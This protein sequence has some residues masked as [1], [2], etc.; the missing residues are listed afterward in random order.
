MVHF[1]PTTSNA[2]AIDVANLFVTYVWKLHG[3]PKKT[4]SDR[5]PNFNSKFLRQLYKRLDI[6]PSFSTAYRSQTD[7]QSERANQVVEGFLRHYVSHRQ[8]NWVALLPMAEFSY[9]NGVQT[10]T[11]KTPFFACYGFHPQ[12]TIGDTDTK[13]VPAA[14]ERADWLKDSFDE[15]RAALETSNQKIKEF[16]DRKHR[17][18]VKI[19]IGDKV[20]IDSRDIQTDRPSK[21]LAAKRLGPFQVLEKIGT[22]AFKLKLPHTMK[23]H[24][25]F[26]VSKVTLKQ[27]DPYEREPVPLPPIITPEGEEEFEVETVLNSK[28]VRGVVKYLIKWKGYGPADNTWEPYEHLVNAKDALAIWD[29][30][31]LRV[32]TTV[33]AT[34]G[35]R[36]AQLTLT[37]QVMLRLPLM[38]SPRDTLLGLPISIPRLCSPI[39]IRRANRSHHP[40][41]T[42][43]SSSRL[44]IPKSANPCL[45]K[46]K[47]RLEE[48]G[49]RAVTPRTSAAPG[50]GGEVTDHIEGMAI[51]DE[52][53]AKRN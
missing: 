21:K 40:T 28:K 38:V 18:P 32:L 12:F 8:D 30:T 53:A 19:N 36:L 42:S 13:D 26:H 9:N 37:H 25:V 24:P 27:N 29:T 5:G 14:D 22:H 50:T 1:I 41:L 31:L 20:F 6:K 35:M 16:Y 4:I 43:R 3:L 11:G 45:T 47:G 48:Y 7:G 49:A 39:P 33:K 44:A 17:A 51:I 34:M 2:T 10:S 52:D 46:R 23:V 15:L